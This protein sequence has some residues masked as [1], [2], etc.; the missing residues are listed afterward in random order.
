MLRA[1]SAVSWALVLAVWAAW[2]VGAPPLY[3]QAAQPPKAASKIET[4]LRQAIAQGGEGAGVARYNLAQWL[5]RAG[6]HAEAVEVARDYLRTEP[7]GPFAKEARVVLC[8]AR[9]AG[10]IVLPAAEPRKIGTPKEGGSAV[11]R[12]Q[13]VHHVKP[14]YSGAARAANVE[15]SVILESLIDEEGCIQKVRLLQGVHPD[16]D[17]AAQDA[18]GQWV[19]QPARMDEKPVTVYYV[20]T[21]G[22]QIDRSGKAGS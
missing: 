11:S 15:G 8:Q 18:V 4:A 16:L 6:R 14:V 13:V 1:R 9:A 20:L 22:F 3:S 17:Q 5:W 10:G 12:P 19:F 7:E 21:V 2:W